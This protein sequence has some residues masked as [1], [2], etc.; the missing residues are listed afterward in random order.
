MA[1]S[2]IPQLPSAQTIASLCEKRKKELAKQKAH[3]ERMERRERSKVDQE[4][5]GNSAQ[6]SMPRNNV[7]LATKAKGLGVR[8]PSSDS[9]PKKLV[10]RRASAPMISVPSNDSA[11]LSVLQERS[12]DEKS[13]PN[14]AL[15]PRRFSMSTKQKR[16]VNRSQSDATAGTQPKVVRIW[17]GGKQSHLS[18]MFSKSTK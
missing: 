13:K 17:F 7:S 16:L 3:Q 1:G 5:M 8:K 11:P 9:T 4:N 18:H 10:L 12:V 6:N 14:S 15:K 2:K